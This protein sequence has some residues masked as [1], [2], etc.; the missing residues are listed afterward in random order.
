MHIPIV[1]EQDEVITYK[2]RKDVRSQDIY[3][4]SSLWITNS[5]G[6]VLLAQRKL[7]KKHD[8]GKWGPAV[9]GTVEKDETYD[10]NIV[11]E[12]DEEIGVR[13]ILFK[14]DQKIRCHGDHNFFLQ[15]YS[16]VL[17][18]PIDKF[19]PQESELERLK[20]WKNEKLEAAI[21][22]NPSQF[23]QYVIDRISTP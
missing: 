9:A 15:Q 2:D 16:L 6:E 23:L 19:S 21:R 12:A 4:V 8:P 14:K 3:R 10:S 1:N 18:W 11:K 22:E 17:D 20:W 5:Q 13:G 7:T